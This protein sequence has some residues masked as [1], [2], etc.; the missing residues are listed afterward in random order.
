M[1]TGSGGYVN[2][3]SLPPGTGAPVA[4]ALV[5]K[6]V[7][8]ESRVNPPL[9]VTTVHVVNDYQNGKND[10]DPD[11]E[12]R[13]CPREPDHSLMSFD[14]SGPA[15]SGSRFVECPRSQQAHQLYD[16]TGC[17]ISLTEEYVTLATTAQ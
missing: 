5:V 6:L 3:L 16:P 14:I 2:V 15:Q 4:N 17:A 11:Y 13:A 7:R 10:D 9:L 1:L 12:L 8:F